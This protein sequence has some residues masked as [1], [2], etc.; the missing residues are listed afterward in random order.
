[1]EA[2]ATMT[3][4]EY[5]RAMETNF[6]PE[7]TYGKSAVIQYQFTGSQTGTCHAIIENGTLHTAQGPHPAPTATVISDFDVWMR[8]MAY[9]QDPLLAYQEGC[10]QV[11]GDLETLMESDSWFPR[12][13]Q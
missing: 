1:V 3:I 4:E 13:V 10:Y 8:V 9:R 12:R 7:R 5:L 2:A 6:S 11:V